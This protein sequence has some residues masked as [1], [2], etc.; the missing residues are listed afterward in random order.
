MIHLFPAAVALACG[1]TGGWF[2]L[3]KAKKAGHSMHP[4]L[5]PAALTLAF[6]VSMLFIA[7]FA[8]TVGSKHWVYYAARDGLITFMLN[9]FML[10]DLA[11]VRKSHLS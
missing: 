2:G 4:R 6:L 11:R 10:K 3:N 8:D 5:V 9:Y 1:V 7:A